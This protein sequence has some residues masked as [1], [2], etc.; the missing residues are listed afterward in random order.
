VEDS[1]VP[2]IY[3]PATQNDP[4]GAE[5][6]VRTQLPPEALSTT[7]MKLLRRINPAQPAAEFRP[8]QHLVDHANSPRRFVVMLVTSFALLGLLLASLGLYAVISYSVNRRTQEIGIRMA[9]GAEKGDVLKMV[10]SQGF[11]LALMGVAIGIA[12]AL[13]LT[14]FLASLLYGVKST[15]PPTFIA[16]SLVLIAVALAACYIPARRAAKVDPMVALRYE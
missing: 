7:V 15:D 3:V 4:E 2:E 10:V 1:D 6:V 11:R 16:V 9:L 5:L 14:H 12:G 8:L 13:A